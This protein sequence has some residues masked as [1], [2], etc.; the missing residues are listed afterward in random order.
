[1]DPKDEPPPLSEADRS[2]ATLL[3]MSVRN[4]LEG[5]L[6][7]G[8][9]GELG[10]TDEQMRLLNPLLRNAIAT[11]L[12]ARSNYEW[13]RS[14]RA[15][16]DFQARLVPDYWEAAELLPDYV[17]SWRSLGARDD[18]YERRCRRCGRAIVNPTGST[19][20]HLAADGALVV[21][22]RAASF[23]DDEGWDDSLDRRWKA[24]PVE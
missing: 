8:E 23:V 16:L 3:A 18:G 10:L 24:R 5:A 11:A 2:L 12:H 6:H 17:D 20:T 13:F 22:C 15:Y 19:W 9:L 21:G 7:G 14:A 4:A 1:M